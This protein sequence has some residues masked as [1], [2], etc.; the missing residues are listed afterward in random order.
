LA[1][2]VKLSR[3]IEDGPMHLIPG[4]RYVVMLEDEQISVVDLHSNDD[5][6]SIVATYRTNRPLSVPEGCVWAA[7]NGLKVYILQHFTSPIKQRINS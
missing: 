4:G 3:D 5:E 1:S 7:D 2:D 6:D